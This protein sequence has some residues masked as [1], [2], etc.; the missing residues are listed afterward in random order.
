MTVLVVDDTIILRSIIRDLLVEFCNVSKSN[1]YEASDG[2]QAV[3]EYKRLRPNVVFMDI[4]MPNLDG[5]ET[6]KQIIEFDPAAKIV[7]CTGTGGEYVVRECVREGAIDYL[8][9]PII[10]A[11]LVSAVRNITG[12]TP[13]V[14]SFESSD[15]VIS[16]DFYAIKNKRDDDSD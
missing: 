12:G 16:E 2:M 8:V 7:M 15:K 11:R 4:A 9:K 5:V 6:V 3:R 1:I 10:P 14:R 13:V